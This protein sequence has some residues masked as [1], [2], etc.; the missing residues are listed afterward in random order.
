MFTVFLVEVSDASAA[1]TLLELSKKKS[2]AD[3][4]MLGLAEGKLF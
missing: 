2:P 3:Y 4:C 1:K